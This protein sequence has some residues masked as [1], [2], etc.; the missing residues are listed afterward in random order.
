MNNANPWSTEARSAEEQPFRSDRPNW[1]MFQ[2]KQSFS[3]TA[4]TGTTFEQTSNANCIA[5]APFWKW[6]LDVQ[7][8]GL[9]TGYYTGWGM[10]GDFF[11][12]GGIII[13]VNC[14]S[15]QNDHLPG[16]FNYAC[17]RALNRMF[18]TIRNAYPNLYMND[19]RPPMNLGIW[20]NRHIDTVFTLDEFGKTEPLPGLRDQPTN[21]IYGDKIRKWSRMRMHH[22][23][24]PHYLDWP[25]VFVAPQ[26][27]NAENNTKGPDWPSEKIDYVMLSAFSCSPNQLFYLPTKQGIPARDKAEIKKWLEWGRTNRYLQVRKD[28]PQWPEAGKVDGS[29]HVAGDRGLFFLFNPN[30]DRLAGHFVI[31]GLSAGIRLE[32]TQIY[33]ENNSTLAV[34]LGRPVTWEV[35]AETVIVLTVAH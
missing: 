17:E 1:R 18:A 29:I 31:D 30:P 9:R 21:V 13:A 2:E 35:P 12:G 16:D 23:L 32:V 11:G 27:M 26:S 22:H 33:P 24:F 5:N 20:S 14:P 4:I 15:D 19:G 7:L 34:D 25:Q 28:L 3:Y 8:D 10:D 6:L